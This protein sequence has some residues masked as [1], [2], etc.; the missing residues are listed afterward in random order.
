MRKRASLL[1]VV[2]YIT[3]LKGE[4][5]MS[6]D[7]EITVT[8]SGSVCYSGKDTVS[9]FRAITIKTSIDFYAKTKMKM[10]G[11][12]TPSLMLQ[13]AGE[14]TGKTYKRGQYNQASEDLAVWIETISRSA[15]ND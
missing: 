15:Y 9:L 13:I 4:S 11:H 1:Y 2:S 10:T 5:Q 12:L 14:Y 3:Y 6:N 7:S 8:A